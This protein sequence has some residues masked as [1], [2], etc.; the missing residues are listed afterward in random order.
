MLGIKTPKRDIMTVIKI[1]N[2]R[3]IT[4]YMKGKVKLDGKDFWVKDIVGIGFFSKL[5]WF[6][7]KRRLK[8]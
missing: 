1:K 6:K 7:T 4:H 3:E 2:I 8:M 5:W